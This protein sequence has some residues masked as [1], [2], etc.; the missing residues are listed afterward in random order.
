MD[1]NTFISKPRKIRRYELAFI[2]EVWRRLVAHRGF[3]EQVPYENS[4]SLG[5]PPLDPQKDYLIQIGDISYR[6]VPPETVREWF[7]MSD[8]QL[9]QLSNSVYGVTMNQLL[10]FQRP[11]IQNSEEHSWM[12][13]FNFS[14]CRETYSGMK[15]NHIP[16]NTSTPY[17]HVLEIRKFSQDFELEL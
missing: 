8:H 5:L 3:Y 12:E 9:M 16:W 2:N 14:L 7:K 1:L 6:Q 10:S 4:E 17:L 11:L 15:N 13:Q